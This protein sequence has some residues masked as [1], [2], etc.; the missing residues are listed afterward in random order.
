MSACCE[1]VLKDGSLVVQLESSKKMNGMAKMNP[2]AAC[3]GICNALFVFKL[4][5]PSALAVYSR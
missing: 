5:F 4:A 2:P 1:L 3:I